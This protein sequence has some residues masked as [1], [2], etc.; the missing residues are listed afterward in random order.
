MSGDARFIEGRTYVVKFRDIEETEYVRLEG[1]D[2]IS[3]EY[4]KKAKE[5]IVNK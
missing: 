2:M 4:D 3:K 5:L 1:C